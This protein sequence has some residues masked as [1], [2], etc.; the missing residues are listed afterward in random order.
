M[1]IDYFITLSYLSLLFF[2]LK[3]LHYLKQTM[4]TTLGEEVRFD[5][6]GDPIA[7]YDLMNWQKTQDGSLHLMKVGYYDDSLAQ[8]LF[9]NESAVQWHKGFQVCQLS[10]MSKCFAL[11]ITIMYSYLLLK[12]HFNIFG[13]TMMI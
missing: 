11:Q 9:I 12:V 10:S 5:E 1:I 7:S 6:N 3:L 4:F 2:S 13:S 8:D